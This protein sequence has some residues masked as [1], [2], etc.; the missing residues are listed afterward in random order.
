MTTYK[1]GN[2]LGSAAAK[3]LFDNAQ[4]LDFA[5][6]DISKAIWQDRLG[7]NRK[8]WY[9]IQRDA[10]EAIS[11][12]GYITLDSF[13]DGATLTLPNQVLRWQENG[14]YYRWDGEYPVGGKVVVEGSA[15]DSSGGIGLGAW[16][17]VGDATLRGNLLSEGDALG[18]AIIAVKQPFDGAL[19]R[20]QHD[21]NAEFVSMFDFGGIEGD[22]VTNDSA[23]L[24]IIEALSDAPVI[25]GLGNTF[26][27][28]AVPSSKRYADGWWLVDGDLI[29]FDYT[30]VFQANRKIIAIGPN[31]GMSVNGARNC[32]A[33]GEDAMR[34]NVFGRH[35]IAIGISALHY[36]NGL[37]AS[38]LEGSRNIAIGGNAGRFIS[39]GNRNII[40]GRDAAHNLTT[41]VMNLVS[42]NGAMM[43]DGPNT[44]DPGVIENQTPLTGS[45][46]IILGTEAGK[47]FNE[48]DAVIIGHQAG[49]YTKLATGIVAIGSSAFLN[50]QSDLSYWGTTQLIVDVNCTYV[51]SGTKTITITATAHGL[52]TGYRVWLRFNTGA[53]ADTTYQDD[54]WFLITVTDANTFTIQSPVVASASGNAE[55]TRV[56]T[57][58]AYSSATG[59]TVGIGRE[60]GNG[61]SNYRSVGVGDR[62]GPKGLGVENT[63][64]GYRA[65]FSNTPGAGNTAIGAYNQQFVTGAGNT[66]LG[67]LALNLLTTG[68][69]NMAVGGHALQ[70]ATTGSNNAAAGTN[71]LRGLTTA[72]YNT[73]LGTDSLRYT[74]AGAAHNFTNCTGIG[75]Q[76]YVSGDNQI[77]L[78]NSLTTT[79]VYGT[80][81]NRSDARDKTDV[82]NTALGIEFING[83]RPVSGRW[84]LR[85]DYY[86]FTEVDTGEKDENGHAI[87]RTEVTFDEE[88]YKAE[89]KKRN[90]LHQWFISQE[91]LALLEKMGLN[92]DDYGLLQHGSVNAGEDV[93]TLGYDEFIPPVVKAIQDCWTRMDEIE[94]R[95]AALESK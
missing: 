60:V 18:D 79:Y 52:S 83:L 46:N 92:P 29:P 89:S 65:F 93:Y 58:T 64:I 16:L 94:S 7:R 38:S 4:N 10:Q 81:Q 91:V 80:V 37:S 6:N 95:V 77:Q 35:N 74:Q 5:L 72:S 57:T 86:T 1:T 51:Q 47:Y 45:R 15:P 44:L 26:L 28:D 87:T 55:Y 31:A 78:G 14:E 2:P 11:S 40:F 36:L 49:E 33:I 62:V 9:G 17:S 21:K 59:E 13:E 30:S 67:V 8:T 23:G 50:F 22:G 75:Y 53:H 19:K 42:G 3:D 24:A 68:G 20:T 34:S 84:N 41:G 43:G 76:A 32:I 12:F 25:F 63:G 70:S 82:E 88:G 56:A 54:N 39:T 69:S 90:R 85:D 27:V 61:V 73:A 66:S 71:A 48:G